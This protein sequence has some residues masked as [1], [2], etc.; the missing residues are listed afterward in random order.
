[1]ETAGQSTLKATRRSRGGMVF[2]CRAYFEFGPEGTSDADRVRDISVAVSASHSAAIL[3]AQ[4]DSATQSYLHDAVTKAIAD[5]HFRQAGGG[6]AGLE[7]KF[8]DVERLNIAFYPRVIRACGRPMR[9]ACRSAFHGEPS[10][11][12]PSCKR[13]RGTRLTGCGRRHVPEACGHVGTPRT[14]I[15]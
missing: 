4:E 8:A 6:H 2:P 11:P 14:P 3:A 13:V 5:T 12:Y 9:P 10:C 15:D 1:M 7:V